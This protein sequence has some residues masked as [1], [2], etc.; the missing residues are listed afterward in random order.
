M[1]DPEIQGGGNSGTGRPRGPGG[2]GAGPAP[3]AD[4]TSGTAA[5]VVVSRDS[6]ILQRVHHELAWRYSTDYKIVTCDY[7]PGLAAQLQALRE[8]GTP[9]ALVVGGV[10]GQDPGDIEV[11]AAVRPVEPTARRVAAVR[12]GDWGSLAARLRRPHARQGRPHG[13]RPGGEPRRGVPPVD[14]RVPERVEQRARR[15]LRGGAGDRRAVVS[16]V[17]GTAGRLRQEPDPDRLLR[18]RHRPRPR[19]AGRPRA[20]VTGPAGCRAPVRGAALDAGKPHGPRDRRGLRPAGTDLGRRRLRR[21]GGRRRAR[22][23]WPWRSTRRPKAC[24]PWWSRRR[25][26]AARRRPAR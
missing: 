12:W 18:R 13:D 1:A 8:A 14:H 16:A 22:P 7:P 25:P 17:P 2:V 3:R 21:G 19:D 4:R 11:F 24:G 5:I 10:S 20:G 6:T 26:S 23:A 9:A 15:R